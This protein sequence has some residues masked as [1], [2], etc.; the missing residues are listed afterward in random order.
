M[1]TISPVQTNDITNTDLAK[2]DAAIITTPP[3]MGNQDLCLLP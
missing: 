2:Y 1:A 3:T